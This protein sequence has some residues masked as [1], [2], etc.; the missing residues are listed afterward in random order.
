MRTH[1]G[2]VERGARDPPLAIDLHVANETQP[3]HF[4][5]ERADAVRQGLR[6]HR[7]H[8]AGEIHRG[9]AFL[10]FLVQRKARSHVVRDIGD[11]DD[12]TE[13]ALARLAPHRV[14]E[15]LG[16]LAVDGD[17][18]HGAQIHAR[19][20]C[21][22]VHAQGHGAG[23]IQRLLREL[24]RQ[25]VT[26]D[27]GFHH[28][29][30]RELVAQHR[31][32]LAEG[33][34][35]RARRLD[36]LAHHELA[37][38]RPF[39]RVGRDHHVMQ[40]AAVV[41]RHQADAVAFAIAPDD[42]G[43]AAFQHFHDRAF[44]PTAPIHAGDAG[45]HAIAMHG[46][47][48]FARRQEQIVTAGFG[49]Q[50]AE[51]FGIGDHR[52]RDQVEPLR[53]GVVA[54]PVGEQLPVA[55]HCCEALGQGI[56]PVRRRQ[57]QALRDLLRIQRAIGLGQQREDRL[58]AGD[59]VFVTQRFTFGVRI[60]GWRRAMRSARRRGRCHAARRLARPRRR[61]E[62]DR[63]GQAWWFRC[64]ARGTG[65]SGTRLCRGPTRA[66]CRGHRLR[67][68]GR[69]L[70]TTTRLPARLLAA[71]FLH[72]GMVHRQSGPPG[73]HPGRLSPRFDKPSPRP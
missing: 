34:T 8:E 17:Q 71:V 11:G 32:D 37:L 6:Q 21:R 1:H 48:Q 12:Q 55:Q 23:F 14:V 10:R 7:H 15:I 5:I 47:A 19:S 20:G 52:A 43:Q 41:G 73:W 53:H 36:D 56:E 24:V 3:I 9:G 2:F 65:C 61:I 25:S 72:A 33:R 28:E 51:A 44:A 45:Q 70:A 58:T 26:V 18:R 30:G 68:P 35:T 59:G 54:A 16:V 49:A 60:E 13:A 62:L 40:Y 42:A 39:A 67:H 4:R 66:A 27:R 50:K 64:V 29:R 31:E 38:A 63:P 69:Q 46:L 22:R 57:G